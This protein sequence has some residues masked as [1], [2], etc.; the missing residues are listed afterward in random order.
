MSTPRTYMAAAVSFERLMQESEQLETELK[1][2]NAAI[3][4]AKFGEFG[5]HQLGV[6]LYS[7]LLEIERLKEVLELLIK[8]YEWNADYHND[9]VMLSAGAYT[10]ARAELERTKK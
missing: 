9:K 10:A 4:E 1:A 7:K 2:A 6:Q 5:E 8:A 3:F